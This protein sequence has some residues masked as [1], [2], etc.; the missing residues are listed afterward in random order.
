[1]LY[2]DMTRKALQIAYDAHKGQTDKTG[3]PY[4]DHPLH[5]AEHIGDDETLITAAL[6]HDVVEDTNITFA[7]LAD[8]GISAQVISALRL[9]THNDAV[10]YMDYVKNIKYSGNKV[11]IAVK[12]AD[13][14]HNMDPGRILT[15]DEK[16][17]RRLEKYKDAIDL[18]ES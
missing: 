2:T 6:L 10:P 5:L 14:R 7:D 8:S 4:I 1:M 12:K 16:A 15:I 3:L 18:L 9:L 17:K 13:L 11:A